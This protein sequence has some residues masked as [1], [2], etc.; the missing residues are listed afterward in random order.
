MVNCSYTSYM[1]DRAFRLSF[2]WRYFSEECDRLKLVFSL[3]K[4]P[5]SLVNHFSRFA[6]AN[7]FDQPV[8]SPAVSNRSDPIRVVL[9]FKD[10]ASADIVRSQLQ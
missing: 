3:L 8:S 4:Y 10:Q 7:A 6:V 5:D 9:S 1:L 2:H